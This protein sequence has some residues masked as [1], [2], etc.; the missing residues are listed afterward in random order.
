MVNEPD[1]SYCDTKT[2]PTCNC[3]GGF[4]PKNPMAWASGDTSS[5][6][7]RKSPLSCGSSGNVFSRLTKMKLPETSR[8]IVDRGIGLKECEEKCLKD[9]YCI[10]FANTDIRNG[11]SGCVIWTGELVDM[12]NYVTGDQD[13]YDKT[14]IGYYE[15][16]YVICCY[17][18]KRI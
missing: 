10:G 18:L 11:G 12:R 4:V 15:I 1:K 16:A 8:V 17:P 5:G 6:C 7:V 3:I 14:L 13:L 2:S 9:C